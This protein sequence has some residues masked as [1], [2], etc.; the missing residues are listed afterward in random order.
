MPS[1]QSKTTDISQLK[2]KAL[3]QI[4]LYK[5]SKSFTIDELTV[6]VMG[7]IQWMLHALHTCRKSK[8]K[9]LFSYKV[10]F[11]NSYTILA[12]K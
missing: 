10:N 5:N 9:L 7:F 6:F 3:V 4:T 8:Y 1:R 12:T 11:V 2:Q